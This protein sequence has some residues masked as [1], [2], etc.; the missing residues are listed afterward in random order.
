MGSTAVTM[1]LLLLVLVC[2]AS[3][4]QC[5]GSMIHQPIQELTAT[6]YLQVAQ[7]STE[8]NIAMSP[9]SIHTAMAML[10]YGAEEYS[11]EQLKTA[12]GLQDVGKR[13]HMVGLKQL[14]DEYE[15]LNDENVTLNIVN[16]IFGAQDLKIKP[17]FLNLIK[18]QFRAEIDT[19]DFSDKKH[20][21]KTINGWVANKTND[22]ITKLVS[23]EGL[24]RDV[25][26]VLMNAVYFKATW[27]KPFDKRGTSMKPFKTPTKGSIDTE[28][29]FL[30]ENIASANIKE[31]DAKLISL[32]Y[33]D[34]NYKMLIFHPNE[35]SSVE[36]LEQKLF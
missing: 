26:M 14:Q 36:Q 24:D 35:G 1:G 16:A 15:N 9:L 7:L 18:N 28:F 8:T 22:L 34:E 21:V 6:L 13:E 11:K 12:L 33:I 23:E 29:M 19:L 30:N 32:P 5:M 31:L 25:R 10:M 20:A 27:L 3:S 2:L 4:Q 17:A